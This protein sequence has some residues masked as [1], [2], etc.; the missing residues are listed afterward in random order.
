MKEVGYTL[1]YIIVAQDSVSYKD[2]CGKTLTHDMIFLHDIY[3]PSIEG[4][5]WLFFSIGISKSVIFVCGKCHLNIPTIILSFWNWYK[6]LNFF[7]SNS[8]RWVKKCFLKNRFNKLKIQYLTVV[9][10]E[11]C[12]NLTQYTQSINLFIKYKSMDKNIVKN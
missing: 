1:R 8:N 3:I 10:I 11:I 2:T 5:K 7:S 4:L 6:I 12:L 9:I